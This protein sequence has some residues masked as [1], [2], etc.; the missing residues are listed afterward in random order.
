MIL[1][2]AYRERIM[3]RE[4]EIHWLAILNS[5]VLVVML[6]GFLSM[7]LLKFVKSDYIRYAKNE[8]DIEQG[9]D[10]VDYSW[11]TNRCR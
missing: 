10:G 5:F 7:I 6:L 4:M 1:D 8:E 11:L 2:V 9:T 3:F